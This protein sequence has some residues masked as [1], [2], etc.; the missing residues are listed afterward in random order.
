MLALIDLAAPP[1]ASPP[2]R[3][4]RR[5]PLSPGAEEVRAH[6]AQPWRMDPALIEGI[7]SHAHEVTRLRDPFDA[8]SGDVLAARLGYLVFPSDS[9]ACG[10]GCVLERGLM[11]RPSADDAR[12]NLRVL[13]ELAHALLRAEKVE[14][15]EAD[16]W[17]LTLALAIPRGA[18]RRRDGARHVPRWAVQIR[19]ET[20]RAVSR[21]A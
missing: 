18:F 17:A 8:A 14:H 10:G 2:R 1:P 13:H 3:R 21:A 4:R 16:V 19:A 20:A 5:A 11:V 12:W 7:A 9:A 15:G 6:L